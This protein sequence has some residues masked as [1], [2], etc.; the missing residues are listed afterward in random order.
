MFGGRD[1]LLDVKVEGCSLQTVELVFREPD[2]GKTLLSGISNYK[3][4]F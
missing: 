4:T 1:C 2:T 3:L